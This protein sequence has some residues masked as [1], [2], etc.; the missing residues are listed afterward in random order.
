MGRKMKDITNLRFGHLVAMKPAEQYAP[1]RTFV[2]LC[3]C[4][5]GREL[6]VNGSNLRQGISTQCTKC[7]NTGDRSR[8][9][10][11]KV[12]FNDGR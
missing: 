8:F 1:S 6:L 10:D 2:W 7:A 3:K 4:D 12:S 9:M 11:K 5:C